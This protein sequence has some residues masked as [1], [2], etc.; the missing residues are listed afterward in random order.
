VLRPGNKQQLVELSSNYCVFLC[1]IYDSTHGG[2][3]WTWMASD[4][5]VPKDPC[6]FCIPMLLY[7][8]RTTA[9]QL[10]P[11]FLRPLIMV[12]HAY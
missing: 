8:V 2:T 4:V 11:H 6:L 9:P 3:S 12:I 7:T 10:L 1:S 5:F